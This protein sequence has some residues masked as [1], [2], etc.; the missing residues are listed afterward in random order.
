MAGL[1]TK[2]FVLVIFMEAMMFYS[3][4]PVGEDPGDPSGQLFS[5]FGTNESMNTSQSSMASANGSTGVV[6]STANA[7]I[8]ATGLN[9]VKDATD[10]AWGIVTRPYYFLD[11]AGAPPPIPFLFCLIIDLMLALSLVSFFRGVQL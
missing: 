7:I 1:G 5:K 9:Y 11:I 4:I 3:M 2:I 6:E 8:G 10:I